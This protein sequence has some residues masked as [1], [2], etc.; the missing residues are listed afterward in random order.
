MRASLLIFCL[1]AVACTGS[2]ESP[3][4]T[5]SEKSSTEPAKPNIAEPNQ[6]EPKTLK[7]SPATQL[8]GDQFWQFSSADVATGE[9][10]K[11]PPPIRRI[12]NEHFAIGQFIVNQKDKW[13]RIKSKINQQ[14][15]ILE[16]LSCGP[17]GKLHECVLLS[18][19]LPSHLHLAL[20]L[21][22]A[23]PGGEYGSEVT[24]TVEW[25]HPKT[26]EYMRHPA[27]NFLYD[28]LKLKKGQNIVWSFI[29][30][31]FAGGRYQANSDQSLIAVINDSQ[32]VIGIK[33][34]VGNAHQ[35]PK[36]GFEGNLKTT[37]KIGTDVDLYIH[38]VE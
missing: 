38:L 28:R 16:Y 37:P 10:L 9:A 34:I 35:G 21:L 14:Q 4:K 26:G 33:S 5:S 1:L 36:Q 24:I 12:D 22:G 11:T 27:A 2:S 13:V 8:A 31:K 6:E 20:L 23:Q 30:S 3:K 29:G 25:K 18:F 15:D 32:A 19:G 7:F 17:R